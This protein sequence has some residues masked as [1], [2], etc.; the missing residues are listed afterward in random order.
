MLSNTTILFTI[1]NNNQSHKQQSYLKNCF[2][3]MSL[4]NEKRFQINF[5]INIYNKK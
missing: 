4:G 2:A 5:L 1:F 3:W